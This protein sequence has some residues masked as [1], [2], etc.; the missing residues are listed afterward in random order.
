MEFDNESPI[1]FTDRSNSTKKVTIQEKN[2]IKFINV[3]NE[4]PAKPKPKSKFKSN[5][6]T[7]G[8]PWKLTGTLF[9]IGFLFHVIAFGAPDWFTALDATGND[10]MHVGIWSACVL[11]SSCEFRTDDAGICFFFAVTLSRKA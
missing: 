10:V 5:L 7:I 4:E 3:E 11:I 9:L 8:W 6:D 2:D 1:S